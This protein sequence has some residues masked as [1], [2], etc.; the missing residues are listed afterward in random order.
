MRCLTDS[1]GQTDIAL[2]CFHY[3][4]VEVAVARHVNEAAAIKSVNF[5]W[6]YVVILA[7]PTLS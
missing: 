4:I 5:G 6:Q 3:T 2:A 1:D 7:Y